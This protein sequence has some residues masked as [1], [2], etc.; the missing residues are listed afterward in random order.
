MQ[1]LTAAC[2]WISY[3]HALLALSTLIVSWLSVH[4][5]FA[6][7]CAG[8]GSV[9]GAVANVDLVF[10]GTVKTIFLWS[11]NSL[12]GTGSRLVAEFK[13]IEIFK[14]PNRSRLFIS[15]G[16]GGAVS[17]GSADCGFPFRAGQSYL[18]YARRGFLSWS[19]NTD[20]CTR[21]SLLAYAEADIR[22]LKHKPS[23]PEDLLSGD[24]YAKYLKDRYSCKICGRLIWDSTV[25]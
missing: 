11:P 14:G 16:W 24:D 1:S 5:S 25:L 15:T 21:T 2:N 3:I 6:C 13:T 8:P 7:D 18:V 12:P 17:I 10:T 20:Y 4:R 23:A 19:Y 22:F 9:A